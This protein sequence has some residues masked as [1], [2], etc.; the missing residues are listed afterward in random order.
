M[1]EWSFALFASLFSIATLI[2]LVFALFRSPWMTVGLY[3]NAFVEVLT[4][5]NLGLAVFSVNSGASASTSTVEYF[6]YAVCAL[7]V[8]LAGVTFTLIERSRFGFYVYSL[9]SFTELVMVFRMH[10]IWF[11]V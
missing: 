11:G 3:L 4:L 10:Q 8:P 9:V 6:F 2:N 1:F 5:F 7:L